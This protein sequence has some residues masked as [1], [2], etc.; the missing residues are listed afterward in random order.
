MYTDYSENT[1]LFNML[2]KCFNWVILH[3]SCIEISSANLFLGVCF[4]GEKADWILKLVGEEKAHASCCEK[5]HK[6]E[7]V[8]IICKGIMISISA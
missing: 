5:L 3:N 2:N 6:A 4:H 1:F 8:E 7:K